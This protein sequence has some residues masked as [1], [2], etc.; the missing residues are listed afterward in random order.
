MQNT[1]R[2]D[3]VWGSQQ[4]FKFQIKILKFKTEVKMSNV[5]FYRIVLLLSQQKISTV[6]IF[7]TSTCFRL[8]N[9]GRDNFTRQHLSIQ[10]TNHS[11]MLW[12]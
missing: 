7:M 8:I 11:T 5:Y 3:S 12:I 10:D 2:F 1:G 9:V 6:G 4:D